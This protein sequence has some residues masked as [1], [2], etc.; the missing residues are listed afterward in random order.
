MLDEATKISE[1][2]SAPVVLPWIINLSKN[3]SHEKWL[4]YW[5]YLI[6][7]HIHLAE[8]YSSTWS[9]R[10]GDDSIWFPWSKH[11]HSSDGKRCEVV[12][13]PDLS[14]GTSRTGAF[15][16]F[17]GVPPI[18]LVGFSMGFST[19]QLEVPRCPVPVPCWA[20]LLR[21]ALRGWGRARS[22][23]LHGWSE[24]SSSDAW[25]T[26]GCSRSPKIGCFDDSMVI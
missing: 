17:M 14:L 25:S 1:Y 24:S 2:V 4:L 10:L 16:E 22:P 12:I 15:L 8:L 26:S 20:A 13:Y 5:Y 6:F 23:W 7:R 18:I 11:H 9:L 19:N 21:S 3:D